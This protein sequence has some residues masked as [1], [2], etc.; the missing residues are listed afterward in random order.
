MITDI[1]ITNFKNKGIHPG[2]TGLGKDGR[3]HIKLT[4]CDFLSGH[5]GSGKTRVIRALTLLARGYIPCGGKN[6]TVGDVLKYTTKDFIIVTGHYVDLDGKKW[7]LERGF[8][9][10]G[11]K[12]RT[13]SINGKEVKDFKKGDE[14]IKQL[15][16]MEDRHIDINDFLSKSDVEKKKFVINFSPEDLYFNKKKVID[17]LHAKLLLD[18]NLTETVALKMFNKQNDSNEINETTDS[19]NN[20][21]L[22]NLEKLIE[23]LTLDGQEKA[24]GFASD[25]DKLWNEGIG[26]S[27]NITDIIVKI[28][29]G[30]S[31]KNAN[32]RDGK[33]VIRKLAETKDR[34]DFS[35]TLKGKNEELARLQETLKEVDIELGRFALK[36]EAINKLTNEKIQIVNDLELLE[37]CIDRGRDLLPKLQEEDF[38]DILKGNKN[39]QEFEI[40]LKENENIITKTEN[41]ITSNEKNLSAAEKLLKEAKSENKKCP[42]CPTVGCTTDFSITTE[43][44]K[45]DIGTYKSMIKTLKMKVFNFEDTKETNLETINLFD[46]K[47][48]NDKKEKLNKKISLLDDEKKAAQAKLIDFDS[49]N[50]QKIGL[51]ANVVEIKRQI[52]KLKEIKANKKLK[53]HTNIDLV[54][55]KEG[56]ELIKK[57][58]AILD[59]RG[60]QGEIIKSIKKPLENLVNEYLSMMNEE[61]TFAISLENNFE[62]GS[63][64]DDELALFST[65]NGGHS[66]FLLAAFLAAIITRSS[67]NWKFLPIEAGEME[68]KNLKLLLRGLHVMTQAKVLDNV[69]VAHYNSIT[70]L[71]GNP[72][73]PI[74]LVYGVKQQVLT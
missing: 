15:L 13:I 20:L 56:L 8:Y 9:R 18:E 73:E 66:P 44:I 1:F 38:L 28:K 59:H 42:I 37:K 7:I 48:T 63:L 40:L 12:K 32:I 14:Q 58:L 36:K 10:K 65:M 70:G 39:V 69:V 72:G 51:G 2:T 52:E 25:V 61:M 16:G 47:K 27:E 17:L 6:K 50:L 55:E 67:P 5:N 11:E 23:F 26:T 54:A 24:A 46:L 57:A 3:I 19:F 49:L 45:V 41:K 34:V 29:E 53:A 35:G 4:G 74:P 21:D 30:E 43:E 68:E 62:M 31:K 33:A 60:I 64:H 71:N 22:D